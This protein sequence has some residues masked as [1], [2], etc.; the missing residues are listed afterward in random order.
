MFACSEL[1]TGYDDFGKIIFLQTQADQVAH[2]RR[3]AAAEYA[4]AKPTE[5]CQSEEPCVRSDPASK[6]RRGIQLF[7][8]MLVD[9]SKSGAA[10]LP[11]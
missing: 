3:E 1:I 5:P 6:T 11:H 10:S 4:H 7:L 9:R 2:E 8:A